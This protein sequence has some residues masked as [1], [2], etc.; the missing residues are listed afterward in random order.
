MLEVQNNVTSALLEY[1]D[2]FVSY[3]SLYYAKTLL[4][5]ENWCVLPRD[6][7]FVLCVKKAFDAKAK[8]CNTE[9]TEYMKKAGKIYPA[10]VS[11]LQRVLKEEVK[12]AEAAKIP[13]E[14]RQLAEELK[15]NVRELIAAG[16]Y[17]E[18]KNFIQ[19]LKEYVPDDEE[20]KVLESLL[21]SW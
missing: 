7:Q 8:K 6:C 3:A 16:E 20:I 11:I 21:F 4:Q 5:E 1:V 12:R 19:A 17:L 10:K 15:K 2:A 14:M 13:P 18:A 9:W